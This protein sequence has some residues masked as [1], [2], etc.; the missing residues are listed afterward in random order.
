MSNQPKKSGKHPNVALK[1]TGM[2]FQ[3]VI[4]IGLGVYVGK[5]LDAYWQFEQAI[6]TALCAL[7]AL[8]LALYLIL[9]DVTR[10]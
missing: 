2:A 8:G 6:M 1:Y 5:R 10:Q 9:K 7:L 3:M 4:I